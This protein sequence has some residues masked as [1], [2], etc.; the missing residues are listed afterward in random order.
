VIVDKLSLHAHLLS[1]PPKLDTVYLAHPF[2]HEIYRHHGLRRVPIS[3][4]EVRFMSLFWTALMKRLGV[5]L[6]LSTAYH[7][8]TD[9]QSERTIGTLEDMIRP[10]LF[11]LQT[12]GANISTN[13]NLLTILVNT[14]AQ[15]KPRF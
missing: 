14:P 15:V 3:D 7:P 11:Y 1:R 9:G 12:D 10:Y 13:W 2:L 6:N 8:Q 4:L 5:K